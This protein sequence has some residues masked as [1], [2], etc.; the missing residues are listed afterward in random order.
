CRRCR[1][2]KS[3]ALVPIGRDRRSANC[4][5]LLGPLPSPVILGY[6]LPAPTGRGALWFGHKHAQIG[7]QVRAP[8]WRAG[9]PNRRAA[10]AAFFMPDTCPPPELE[11]GAHI[12]TECPSGLT[13][14][15]S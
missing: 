5:L 1:T 11:A 13:F 2:F 15:R 9:D 7:S 6:R 4:G 12:E 3:A 8:K 14:H 10:G